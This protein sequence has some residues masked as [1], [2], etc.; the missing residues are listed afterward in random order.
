LRR[1]EIEDVSISISKLGLDRILLMYDAMEKELD[2]NVKYE[3]YEL[4]AELKKAMDYFK[5]NVIDKAPKQ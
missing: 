2:S 3:N 1:K 5:T 4:A